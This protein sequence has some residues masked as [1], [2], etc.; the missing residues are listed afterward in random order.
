MF[1]SDMHFFNPDE[2]HEF[3]ARELLRYCKRTNVTWETT[4]S[5][6]ASR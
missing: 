4:E 3:Y 2:A 5:G 1:Y 6:A